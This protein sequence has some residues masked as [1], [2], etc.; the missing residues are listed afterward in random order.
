MEPPQTELISRS[1]NLRN[2]DQVLVNQKIEQTEAF[3]QTVIPCYELSNEYTVI[4]PKTKKSL[5]FIKEKSNMCCRCCLHPIHPVILEAYVDERRTKKL[6][7]ARKPFR[8]FQCC[9]IIPMCCSATMYTY[10]NEGGVIG[11]TRENWCNLFKPTYEVTSARTGKIGDIMGPAVCIGG[12]SSIRSTL[13]NFYKSS[14]IGDTF[15]ENSAEIILQ[16]QNKINDIISDADKYILNFNDK[17]MSNEH[18]IIMISSLILIDYVFFE[19]DTS[20]LDKGLYLGTCYCCGCQIPLR[21]N[22]F[23]NSSGK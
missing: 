18:K 8:C 6:F 13:F 23:I 20:D 7:S 9:N 17:N 15:R 11:W 16:P 1:I 19:G 5:V 22:P 14:I 2:V 21:C 4:N 10:N 12:V 3:V